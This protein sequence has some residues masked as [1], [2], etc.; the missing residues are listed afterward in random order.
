MDP[1][2]TAA[3]Y[4]P[5]S[6]VAGSAGS[7]GFDLGRSCQSVCFPSGRAIVRPSPPALSEALIS[8]R[9][10]PCL[11]PSVSLIPAILVGLKGSLIV[12]VT[13]WTGRQQCA[14][15][16]VPWEGRPLPGSVVP[17]PNVTTAQSTGNERHDKYTLSEKLLTC[18]RGSW[19]AHKNQKGKVADLL[20]RSR[21]CPGAHAGL[22]LCH[23]ACRG[24]SDI[25]E[26]LLTPNAPNGTCD[27]LTH[28]KVTALSLCS[29]GIS[30]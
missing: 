1:V 14:Q 13:H 9:P 28:G 29:V 6:G 30:V 26:T 3:E 16:V 18:F 19:R 10:C 4:K 25:S 15:C 17:P 12:V 8:P 11:L 21:Q 22:A 2:F 24:R 5:P 20:Q 27:D 7:P 23:T